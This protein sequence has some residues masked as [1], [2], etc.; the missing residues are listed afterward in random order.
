[1]RAETTLSNTAMLRIMG[2]SG[3][4][5]RVQEGSYVHARLPVAEALQSGPSGE[6][7]GRLARLM[8]RG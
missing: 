8:G 4:S 7:E 3:A 5:V 2:R 6:R 1:M